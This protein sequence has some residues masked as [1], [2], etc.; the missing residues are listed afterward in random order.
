MSF[1]SSFFAPVTLVFGLPATIIM[2]TCL[3]S[4]CIFLFLIIWKKFNGFT[5]IKKYEEKSLVEIN[6]KREEK[7]DDI[8]TEAVSSNAINKIKYFN[9]VMILLRDIPEIRKQRTE[10]MA[11][12]ICGK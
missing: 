4:S 11:K 12:K 2:V 6:S 7:I 5:E 8:L 9:Q 10:Q 3:S 1:I